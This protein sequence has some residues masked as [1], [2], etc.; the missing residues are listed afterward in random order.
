MK[1]NDRVPLFHMIFNTIKHVET[2]KT[3][4]QFN[5]GYISTTLKTNKYFQR[6]VAK[7]HTV[8]W[9]NDFTDNAKYITKGNSSV[10]A[11]LIKY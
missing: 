3:I 1:S 2:D 5:V 9:Y 11:I 10:V 8:V 7:F 4:T 6:K